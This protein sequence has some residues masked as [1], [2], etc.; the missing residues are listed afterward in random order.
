[1]P[2]IAL[3]TQ[4]MVLTSKARPFLRLGAWTQD[5]RVVWHFIAPGKPMQNGFC[6]SFNGRMRDELLNESFVTKP[7]KSANAQFNTVAGAALHC[8]FRPSVCLIP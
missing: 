4:V 5:N 2:D 3:L 7:S 6:E 1:M 8:A